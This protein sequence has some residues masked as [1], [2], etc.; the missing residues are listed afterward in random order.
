MNYK[1]LKELVDKN[2]STRRIA[3]ELNYSQTNVRHWL[4]KYELST[5]P[6]FKK[7]ANK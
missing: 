4:K 7:N 1:E 6:K 2:Y 5:S 3:E